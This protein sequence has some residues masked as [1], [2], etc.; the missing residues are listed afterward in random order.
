MNISAINNNYTGFVQNSVSN[1]PGTAPDENSTKNNQADEKEIDFQA[2]SQNHS[3]T[4][5]IQ[6]N[7]LTQSEMLLLQDLKQTDTKVRQHEMA[8]IAAGGQ[9]ITTGAHFTYKQGP[10]GRNYVV[11]GEVG[12]D[13]SPVPGDPQATIQKMSQVKNAAL[14]P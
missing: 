6:G 10:D 5:D 4:R 7:E 9:Y 14:A 13:T 3:A 8:H 12:I 11:G 2:D 1:T